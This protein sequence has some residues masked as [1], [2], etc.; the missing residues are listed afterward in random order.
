MNNQ[1][2]IVG[3]RPLIRVLHG[4]KGRMYV[5]V[6]REYAGILLSNKHLVGMGKPYT[7]YGPQMERKVDNRSDGVKAIV[8]NFCRWEG[9][10]IRTDMSE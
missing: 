2:Y 6:N 3:A 9:G 1:D 10:D 8:L 7:A 4:D 5:Y